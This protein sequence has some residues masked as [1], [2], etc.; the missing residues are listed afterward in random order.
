[1]KMIAKN[2]LGSDTA[3]VTFSSIPGTYTDLTLVISGRS[4]HSSV[5]DALIGFNSSTSS[6][7]SRYLYG[8]GSAVGSSTLARY[9][10]AVSGTPTTANTFG[11]SET[12]I[13]NYAGATNKSYST[14]TVTENNAASSGIYTEAIA[15]L[16]SNTAAIT[17]I[18]LTTSSG[19][20][21]S[22]SSFFLYGITKA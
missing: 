3:T 14:T 10:G 19:S 9:L 1:M 8:T 6:F 11:S 15:G 4:T 21:L 17:S 20:W 13:P 22:G 7:S 18:E 12:Y 5:V 2:V 16:W